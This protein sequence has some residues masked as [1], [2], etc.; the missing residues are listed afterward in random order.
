MKAFE[1]PTRDQVSETSQAIFD[2]LEKAIGRVP[3]LYATIGYSG[4][5]LGAFLAYGQGL[6]KGA[7]NAREREAIFLA[8]SE[9]NQ[10]QYCLAAHTAIAK[11]N[12]F[13]DE[14]TRQLRA[15]THPDAKLR[16]I[17]LLAADISRSHG[18]PS[19]ENLTNFFNE[20]FDNGALIDL[21]GLVTEITF[22]NY[23]HKV[24]E[25]PVDFPLAQPLNEP[26]AV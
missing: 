4:S 15:G 13:S 2:Q 6:A 14:E 20:G 5:T 19:E 12:K 23:T 18:E 25:V 24:T 8:V 10:C 9:V 17:T 7:F 11:M 26:V 3:N 21:I 1:V 22:T 16:A